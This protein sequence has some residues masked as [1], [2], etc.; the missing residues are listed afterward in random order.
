MEK[1]IYHFQ[2][3]LKRYGTDAGF[4]AHASVGLLHVRPVV[5]M[6]TEEGIEPTKEEDENE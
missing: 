5:N 4:Y 6:K 1:F 3:I 2:D